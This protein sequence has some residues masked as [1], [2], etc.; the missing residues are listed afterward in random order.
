VLTLDHTS[1]STSPSSE[2]ASSQDGDPPVNKE[3][4]E[5]RY[6]RTDSSFT[7]EGISVQLYGKSSTPNLTLSHVSKETEDHGEE[8]EK[9]MYSLTDI[10]K[11]GEF[12][13]EQMKQY[14]S[15]YP[16]L[17]ALPSS[18]HI[19]DYTYKHLL[20]DDNKKI[21]FCYIPKVGCSNWKRMFVVLNGILPPTP[22]TKRPPENILF[23]AK[24]LFDLSASQRA[25]R[26]KNY[27]KFMMVRNPLERLVSAYLNK[28]Y[29]PIDMLHKYVFPE[30]EKYYMLKY[31][32]RERFLN[33]TKTRQPTQ[34]SPSFESYIKFIT[35]ARLQPGVRLN[36]HLESM[37]TLCQP[38]V[39]DYD[40]YANFKYLPEDANRF[41]D[42]FGIPHFYYRDVENHP[43]Y[44]T[45]ELTDFFYGDMTLEERAMEL[46]KIETRVKRKI[47]GIPDESLPRAVVA[48][49]VRAIEV[50]LDFY[51][52]LYPEEKDYQLKYFKH[53]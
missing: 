35:N 52:S 26:L 50:D 2:R 38:C 31:F 3:A 45:R 40:Y 23:S 51:G 28:I 37:T 25:W 42:K 29:P 27:Y 8:R 47:P 22:S 4:E 30:R 33:W 48:E 9:L 34:I 11:R 32:E 18:D 49:L 24:R 6:S 46:R 44:S 41:M 19:R 15:R 36:E 14:C 20:Y 1:P 5:E 7:Q 17:K 43:I 21:I 16:Q 12:Q 13:R 53:S 39:F 10:D